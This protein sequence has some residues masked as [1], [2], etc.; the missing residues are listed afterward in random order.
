[1]RNPSIKQ[2]LQPNCD[3]LFDVSKTPCVCTVCSVAYCPLC[4]FKSHEGQCQ[5]FH[6]EFL[7]NNFKYRYLIYH[8]ESA[9]SAGM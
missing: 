6:V 7:Q 8:L 3:G 9:I 5:D 2:C 4:S 1:M